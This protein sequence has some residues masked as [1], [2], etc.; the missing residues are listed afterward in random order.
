[1]EGPVAAA[2]WASSKRVGPCQVVEIARGRLGTVAREWG[3]DRSSNIVFID[4]P[5][6]VGFSYDQ[7][8]NASL[9]LIDE[10]LQYP[11]SS[12]PITQPAYIFLNGTFSSD[13]SNF[14]AN[15]SHIAAQAIWHFLQGFL[16]TFPEY[17]PG[18]KPDDPLTTGE[19]GVNLFTESYGGKYGPAIGS[20][21]Q[22]QNTRRQSDPVF[23]NATL[24]TTLQSLGI[25]N[26]W[27]DLLTQIP[28]HPQFAF[29][30]SY[31]HSAY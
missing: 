14:T 5:V 28:F 4:Q 13:N 26:G 8:T 9:N 12:R 25:M 18:L 11:P 30:N 27:I 16:T 17:N 24:Q 2:W 22:Q 31:G 20:F 10:T 15:T 7:P 23:A 21:F 6:Q 29:N 3:W 1:M 19:V